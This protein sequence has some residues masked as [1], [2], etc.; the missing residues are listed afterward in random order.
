M[1]KLVGRIQEMLVVTQLKLP[2]SRTV[3]KTP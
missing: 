1:M 3:S 2:L